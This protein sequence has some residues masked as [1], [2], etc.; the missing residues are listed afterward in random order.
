VIPTRIVDGPRIVDALA[1]AGLSR[2]FE[3]YDEAKALI[4]EKSF[5]GAG[6]G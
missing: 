2:S 3:C 5:G 4:L 1:L 6:G